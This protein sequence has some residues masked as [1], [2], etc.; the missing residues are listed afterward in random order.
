MAVVLAIAGAFLVM[1]L[2]RFI[3]K[4]FW[5]RGLSAQVE[6]DRGAVT[7]GEQCQLT[8]TVTNRKW[9]PLPIVQVKFRMGRAIHFLDTHNTATTD[10]SYRNDIFCMLPYQKITRKMQVECQKRGYYTISSL[11]LVTMNLLHS[12]LLARPEECFTQ[13]YVYPQRSRIKGLEIPFSHMMGQCLV[14]RFLYEDPFEFRGI[15]PYASTDNM[16]KINWGASAKTGELKVNQFHDTSQQEVTLLLNLESEGTRVY[17]KL[18]EESI[19]IA[20]TFTEWLAAKGVPVRILSNGR[21]TVTGASV[22]CSFGSGASHALACQKLLARIDLSKNPEPFTA[23]LERFRQ[24]G[25]GLWM[26]ISTSQKEAVQQLAA[27]CKAGDSAAQWI[28]PLH[29]DMEHKIAL[30]GVEATYF[31]VEV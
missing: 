11:D 27:R 19:R 21:D 15:R 4:R 26:M 23:V 14:N 7:E 13:L 30:P 5:S 8:E 24:E 12:Q 28:C 2:Q 17:D 1:L 9:M 29:P 16:K 6:F 3:W 25:G 18:R 31:R 22:Q 10:L 20:R